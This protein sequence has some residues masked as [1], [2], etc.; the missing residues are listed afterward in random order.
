MLLLSTGLTWGTFC[1]KE[2][3]LTRGRRTTVPDICA[4]S[5]LAMRSSSAMMEAYSV[6]CAPETRASS[7]PG[8][9]PRTMTT[10]ICVPVS[11]PAGTS[12]KPVAFWP[13]SAVAVPTVKV[14]CCANAANDRKLATRAASRT[15]TIRGMKASR[16]REYRGCHH[17]EHADFVHGNENP[18]LC[19]GPG[20]EAV[21]AGE[22]ARP[23]AP[24]EI[25]PQNSLAPLL[26]FLCA[27]RTIPISGHP[28]F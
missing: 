9:A 5:R 18:P 27:L 26:D 24:F 16:H 1:S 25:G 10:G 3:M 8:F 6:P 22:H 7:A 11:V 12:M 21:D 17:A 20:F 13:R 23:A 19:S 28:F 15:R 4:G 2:G 14:D